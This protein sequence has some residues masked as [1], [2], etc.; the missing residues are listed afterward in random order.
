MAGLGGH[1][2][3]PHRYSFSTA[4]GVRRAEERAHVVQ[5]A[6]VVEQHRHRQRR[7][8]L[9]RRAGPENLERQPVASVLSP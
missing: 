9:V 8:A 7:D 1:P 6:H 3:M 2:V 5:A 4:G